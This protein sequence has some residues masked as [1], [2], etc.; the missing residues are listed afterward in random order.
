MQ[1]LWES[2]MLDAGSAAWLEG[3]YEN[4]L[5]NPNDVDSHWREYFGTLPRING[6][7]KDTIHSN[8]REEFRR[9]TEKRGGTQLPPAQSVSTAA[10][11]H[12]RKQV[13]VLQ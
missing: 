10:F 2:S 13:K 8:V 11:E 5:L 9:I 3:L 6:T 1:E 7:L 4:Y 12:E